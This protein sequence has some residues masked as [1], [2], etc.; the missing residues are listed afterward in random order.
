M[1]SAAPRLR[2]AVLNRSFSAKAGGAER[3]SVALVEQLAARHEIHVFAQFIE[4]AASGALPGVSYHQ[5]SMPLRRPRWVNQL[6]YATSTWWATRNGFDV[7]HSHENTWY[8]N[9]QTVHVLP[10][11]HNLFHG[12]TGG[13]LALRWLKVLTS[14]RLLVYLWLESRRYAVQAGRAVVVT[15]DSLLSIFSATYPKA[16]G[17]TSVIT[18]GIDLP[19]TLQSSAGKLAARKALGLPEGKPCVL[20]VGN[21]FR[22]KGLQTLIES[23]RV[24]GQ[25]DPAQEVILAVVGR[26]RQLPQFRQQAEQA[27]LAA[28][29][30]FL[31]GLSDVSVAYRAADCLAHPTLEDT[32]AMVVLE[33]MA[34]GLPVIVSSMKYCGISG[35]LEDGSSA[36]VLDDPR[37]AKALASALGR[38]LLDDTDLGTR[39]GSAAREL[40][41]R[42]EWSDVAVL[43][44]DI[45][46]RAA[47][48]RLPQ[49]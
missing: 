6:W 48:S 23:V 16:V 39:L 49:A 35:L 46:R 4:H 2:I 41:S 34:H 32:F 22:K 31:G 26:S 30:F 18:P 36:L 47:C 43:Q 19:A 45:Y 5:V 11:K 24:L 10:V 21:D 27:G 29:V 1:T 13:R 12:R 25:G 15:S 3:Y 8:G 42:H 28:R 37:D 20:F 40:A 7:V 38:V 44:D 14:P 33:A 9:V 17:M